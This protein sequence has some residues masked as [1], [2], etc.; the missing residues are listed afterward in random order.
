MLSPSPIWA[1][2]GLHLIIGMTWLLIA[3]LANAAS[4]PEI[5]ARGYLLMDAATGQVLA[6]TAADE[7][8]EPASLTKIMTA[9]VV[10]G[11][12]AKGSV[13]MDER[14]SVSETAF[15]QPGSRMFID[16][17]VPVSIEELLHGMIIQSGN[18][19][20][21]A[22]AERIAGSETGFAE[23]MNREA[24]RLGM[25]NSHFMNATGLPSPEHY[26][27]ARDL[28]ILTRAL[29]HDFPA[30]YP[31][32]SQRSYE[33]NKIKQPNRNGLL[34]KDAS[35]D[36]V[37]TGHTDAAGYC[38]VSSAKRGDTRLISVLLG[39]KSPKVREAESLALLNYGFQFFETQKLES[40]GKALAEVQVWF[41]KAS[42]LGLG[43]G[44]DLT[45]TLPKGS[46][47]PELKQSIPD[48]IRA[49]IAKGQPLGELLVLS[50]EQVLARV[51]LLALDEIPE[52]GFFS[53]LIDRIRLWFH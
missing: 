22:L 2:P 46:P 32:Y 11:E 43:L 5:K 47:R 25:A 14:L 3:G 48:P 24:K 52:G 23:L 30:L 35:V 8:L 26:A 36:G 53:R 28:A 51:P 1:Y 15:R 20:S 4:P 21:T 49:P 16:R 29:I 17:K 39:A 13:R 7:R 41:G 37:K 33:Y 50:G 38:L 19:A 12:L 9:Y 40:A 31:I 34:G 27:T 44:Q 10:F 18:D 45:L 6:E 42:R